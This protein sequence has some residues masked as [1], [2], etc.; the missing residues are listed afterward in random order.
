MC[1][2]ES[3]WTPVVV[4]GDPQQHNQ[5]FYNCPFVLR[6]CRE[7]NFM[8]LNLCILLLG[9]TLDDMCLILHH[10][11]SPRLTALNLG[12]GVGS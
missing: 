6:C 3:P 12:G 10:L 4:P 9:W 1:C 11:K 7:V 5:H 2:L 8:L